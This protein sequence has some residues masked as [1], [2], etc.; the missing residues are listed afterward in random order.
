MNNWCKTVFGTEKPILAMCHLYPM[1]SDPD[2]D[3]QKGVS[4]ICEKAYADMKALQSGG[5]DGIIFS[6][7]R[8]QP[9]T[10]KARQV[11]PTT[12][13][14]VIGQLK[15]DLHIPFG[16]DVIWDPV[17]SIDL[18]V[19]TGAQFVR[20]V[21]TGAYASDYGLWNTNLGETLRHRRSLHGTDI[22]L[23]FNITP[24]A[25]AYMGERGLADIT[26]TTVFNGSPDGLCVSGI[27]AGDE[28]SVQDLT[29]AREFAGGVPVFANTGVRHE[30]VEA[31]LRYADGAIV[32]TCFKQDGYIWNDVEQARVKRLMDRVYTFRE[33]AQGGV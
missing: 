26:V 16:V 31:Q 11:I 24:E 29:L 1:P 33:A 5:V 7:E 13:A 9:R 28:T 19:A 30:N 22:K 3:E 27:K 17:S 4:Y 18:A 10:T 23:L 20:E 14:Y 12:M 21:F 32:G 2:Y 6:N 8:S 15:N 25:A